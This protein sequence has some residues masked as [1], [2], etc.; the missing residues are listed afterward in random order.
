MKPKLNIVGF[1][2]LC[3][4]LCLL[5]TPTNASKNAGGLT[6]CKPVES[7]DGVQFTWSGGDE[8]TSYGIYRRKHGECSWE[9]LK[10]G[11]TGT[12]GTVFVRGF[13]LDSDYDYQL[14][15]EQ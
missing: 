2:V 3:L 5:S 14:R 13:T 6:L 15:A 10:S 9:L 8:E 1:S 12:S 11:M 4:A 7:P